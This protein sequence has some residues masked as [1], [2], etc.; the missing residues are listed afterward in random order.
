MTHQQGREDKRKVG[1]EG[2][3]IAAD[4]LLHQG[5]EIIERN[6]SKR[7]GETDIIAWHIKHYFGRTLCFIEVKYRSAD[8]GSAERSVGKKKQG[9]MAN[10]ARRYCLEHG[11]DIEHT[12]IQFEQV[13]IYGSGSDQKIFHYEIPK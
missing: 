13:S 12:P 4:F 2:E 1:A 3:Q 7:I 10:S 5:Y 9:N 8:D 6:F 11:I